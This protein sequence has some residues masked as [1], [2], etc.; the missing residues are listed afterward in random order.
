MLFVGN[1][2]QHLVFREN[3]SVYTGWYDVKIRKIRIMLFSTTSKNCTSDI[4]F[5]IIRYSNSGPLSVCYA[6]YYPPNNAARLGRKIGGHSSL[7]SFFFRKYKIQQ[8]SW[9]LEFFLDYPPLDFTPILPNYR[10]WFSSLWRNYPW[11]SFKRQPRQNEK[12]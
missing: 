11:N 1:D 8:N 5:F 7:P 6:P 10:A 2:F 4:L 12:N 3:C 9:Y